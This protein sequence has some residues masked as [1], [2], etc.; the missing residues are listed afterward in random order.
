MLKTKISILIR[1]IIISISIILPAMIYLKANAAITVGPDTLLPGDYRYKCFAASDGVSAN[2]ATSFSYY[3]FIKKSNAQDYVR[4]CYTCPDDDTFASKFYVTLLS[5]KSGPAEGGLFALP[6]FVSAPI[7][8]KSGPSANFTMAFSVGVV[9][10]AGSAIG[11]SHHYSI[12]VQMPLGYRPTV[13]ARKSKPTERTDPNT[14]DL[15]LP[16]IAYPVSDRQLFIAPKALAR[17]WVHLAC[18]DIGEGE[19]SVD[20]NPAIVK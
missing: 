17:P 10:F 4:R 8:S 20:V 2:L 5:N 7:N 9:P 11:S 3:L 1:V 15:T 19:F 14:L 6:N 13:A 12:R 16:W 18:F